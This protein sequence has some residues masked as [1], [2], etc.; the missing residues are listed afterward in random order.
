VDE[1]RADAA[2]GGAGAEDLCY[3]RLYFAA[4]PLLRRRKE[5]LSCFGAD[6]LSAI[7]GGYGTAGG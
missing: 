7:E 6:C 5:Y 4:T 3:L 2:D 1:Y